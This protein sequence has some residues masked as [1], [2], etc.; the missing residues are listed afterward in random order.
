MAVPNWPSMQSPVLIRCA[1]ASLWPIAVAGICLTSPSWIAWWAILVNSSNLMT[2]CQP[3][4][5]ID[6]A[7]NNQFRSGANMSACCLLCLQPFCRISAGLTAW[8]A[9][10]ANCPNPMVFCQPWRSLHFGSRSRARSFLDFSGAQLPCWLI[11]LALA[12][13]RW[14]PS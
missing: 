11:P 4:R 9:I 10:L 5:S 6:P 2:F 13:P 12:T 1:L 7:W 8:C 3:C 14:T